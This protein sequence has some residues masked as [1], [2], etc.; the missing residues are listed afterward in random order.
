MIIFAEDFTP[1]LGLLVVVPFALAIASRIAIIFLKRR[2]GQRPW[3][4]LAIGSLSILSGLAL[5]LMFLTTRG[6]APS[7]LYL[8]AAFPIFTGAL[9]LIIWLQPSRDRSR[10]TIDPRDVF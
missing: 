2:R 7:F 8:L 1:L 4:G 6:G 5:V 10:P 3:W 9:C